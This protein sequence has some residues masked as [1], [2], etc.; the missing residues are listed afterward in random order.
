MAKETPEELRERL[1][2][3]TF[4]SSYTKAQ[5]DLQIE[6]VYQLARIAESLLWTRSSAMRPFPLRCAVS[7]KF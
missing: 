3:V 4:S 7:A 1:K 6:Q 2:N 5:E